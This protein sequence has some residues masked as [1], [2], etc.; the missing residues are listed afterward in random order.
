MQNMQVNMKTR[1]IGLPTCLITTNQIKIK[2]MSNMLYL[3]S[4]SF[5]AIPTT[6]YCMK[7]LYAGKVTSGCDSYVTG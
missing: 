4:F 3:F 5:A 2:I 7:N 1:L 6:A